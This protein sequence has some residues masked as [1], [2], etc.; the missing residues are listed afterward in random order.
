MK[1]KV[2]FL[3]GTCLTIVFALLLGGQ[4]NAGEED[5]GGDPAAAGSARVGDAFVSCTPWMNCDAG[6][7]NYTGQC[8]RCCRDGTGRKEWYCKRV[9]AEGEPRDVL[10]AGDVPAGEAVISGIVT[11]ECILEA[12]DGKAYAVAGERAEELRRNMG[13]KI[14]VKGTV[15]E[16]QGKVTVDVKTYELMFSEDPR[17]G[18]R[19][20]AGRH[21]GSCTAWKNCRPQPPTFTG[22]CCRRCEAK[23][24]GE[25]WDCRVFSDGEYFDLAEWLQ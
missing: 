17:G 12:D 18:A 9:S 14:E 19:S 23:G 24:G 5:L 22:T 6:S 7:P 3:M 11:R 4:T 15:A 8:C 20:P 10:P 21:L 16:A 2:V 25:V 1:A 13:K